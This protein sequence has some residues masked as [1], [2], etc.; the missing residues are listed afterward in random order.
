VIRPN[1]DSL[2]APCPAVGPDGIDDLPRLIEGAL[3]DDPAAQSA[4]VQRYTRRIAG[5]VRTIVRQPDAV[6]DVTQTVFIKM[7]RRLNRLRDARAFESWLFMLARNTSL[8][9][10]RR[11]RRRPATVSADAELL[12]LPDPRPSDNSGEILTAL[13]CALDQLPLQTRTLVTLYVAGN[14]YET[15]A[16]RE[17][18]TLGAVKARLHRA[19]P[20]LRA[21]IGAALDGRLPSQRAA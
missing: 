4:L 1:I 9:L 10:L 2:A 8:D 16:A 21:S 3:H 20:L 17:G 18:L 14:S 5:F 11:Q 19:R 12:E 13:D 15:L 6:E 7:F